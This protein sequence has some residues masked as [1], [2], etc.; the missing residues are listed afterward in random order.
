MVS[1]FIL[2]ILARHRQVCTGYRK[3]LPCKPPKLPVDFREAL[4][5]HG[6]AVQRR[7]QIPAAIA[8]RAGGAS[9]ARQHILDV[10][11]G[12]SLKLCLDRFGRVLLSAHTDCFLS[13]AKRF[14]HQG[15]DLV[16]LRGAHAQV[17][18]QR[19]ILDLTFHPRPPAVQ[20]ALFRKDE[21]D[22]SDWFRFF[23]IVLDFC[24]FNCMGSSCAGFSCV[25]F[26][27]TGFSRS[28]FGALLDVGTGW[29]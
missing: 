19:D 2:G 18:K 29:T 16:K 11:A 20:L 4:Q 26:S 8:D 6:R 24:F 25:G 3:W 5:R 22:R 23:W 10:L 17:L 21:M 1:L 14:G 28:G 9:H 7:Q 12:E 13:G 15:R 27:S